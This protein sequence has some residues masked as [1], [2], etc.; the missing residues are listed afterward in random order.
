MED[1]NRKPVKARVLVRV[2]PF[3]EAEG[4]VCPEDSPV[5]REI[6]EWDGHHTLTVLDAANGFQPRKNAQFEIDH[7]MWSFRDEERPKVVVHTQ[8]DVYEAM[9]APMIPQLV[10]GCSTAF[11]IAGATGSG[12]VYSL[13]GEDVDGTSRGILPRF[14]EDIFAA[15]KQQ[16]RENSTLTC[17]I[18]AIDVTN[19]ETYMDLLSQRRKASAAAAEDLK[20]V[21]DPT[22]GMKV[23]GATRV[24][25]NKAS[26]LLSV[27]RQVARVVP[28]RNCCHTV[29]LR[30]VET[31]EFEDPEQGDQAV[32]KSRRINVLF[33]LLR[34]MPP[35]FQRCVDVAVE[36]DSGENP[37]AKVPTRETAFTK[38]HPE[39]LQ[40]GYNLAFLCC[41]SPFYE[42]TRD[43]V[44]TL[45]L[46]AKLM[47]LRC[48]PKLNQDAA[49][50]ELRNLAD[51]VRNLKTEVVKQTE[52][53]QIVQK[54][55]NAREVELM[56]QEAAHHECRRKLQ[57]SEDEIAAAKHALRLN[58]Y[59]TKWQKANFDKNSHDKKK[60]MAATMTAKEATERAADAEA[61]EEEDVKAKIKDVEQRLQAQEK[62]NAQFETRLNA[63]SQK[64]EEVKKMRRFIAAPLEERRQIIEASIREEAQATNKDRRLE[65]ELK[66]QKE[67]KEKA[68]ARCSELENDYNAIHAAEKG[69]REK[70]EMQ[71]SIKQLEKDISMTEAET[72]R[73]QGELDKR[74]PGCQC[75]LM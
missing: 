30:F 61:K 41:V 25:V 54:E 27:L 19:N 11:C 36:H 35:A 32:S 1:P 42:H 13:Y 18:E 23:Q 9:V 65:S 74:P 75:I 40:Q 51:E 43:T 53:T 31:Y 3:T 73:L 72:K 39:L 56:K 12:R 16:K 7:V 57:L 69:T 14:A 5:P 67:A 29:H 17:E 49:L 58:L 34:N 59:R 50:V 15:F 28:K 8:K 22:E 33:V 44:Q 66:A 2:R 62:K 60:S 71:K 37:L 6:I 48:K 20:L 70:E 52:S 26:D 47:R 68:Q 4:V 38:L 45:L 21:H 46:A 64:E 55:L 24:P 10:E 63:R